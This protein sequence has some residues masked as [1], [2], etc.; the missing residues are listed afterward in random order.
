MGSRFKIW[1]R[2]TGIFLLGIVV[3]GFLFSG[4]QKRSFL[5]MTD[6]QK[7]CLSTNE[8]AG[9]AASIGIQKFDPLIP[10]KVLETDKT[11]AI[12]HPISEARI[13]YVII[14]KRD[15]LNASDIG[16]PDVEYLKDAYAVI[17]ELIR[18]DRL[19]H[20]TLYTYGPGY[21]NVAY[22]H[23]HLKAD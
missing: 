12:R 5:N 17:G 23:F 6:C 21:Q 18:K 2:R 15:I 8:L 14:P 19:T 1:L 9:L 20:Y 11:I 16:T 10:G 13:Q 7:S 4:T 3:G 22:L